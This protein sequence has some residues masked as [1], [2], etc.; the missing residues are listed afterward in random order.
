M[1]ALLLL[2]VAWQSH[3]NPEL[4]KKLDSMSKEDQRWRIEIMKIR[5][6]EKSAYTEDEINEQWKQA[7]SLNELKV[8]QIINQY[9]YPGYDMVGEKGS[10]D[11]WIIVQHCDD[12]VPFQEKV[13]R[14]MKKQIDLKNASKVN[15]A[16]LMDRVLVNKN[17]KQVYGTQCHLN[18]KTHKWG[19]FPLK[20]PSRVDIL[21]K[22]MG[23]EPLADYLKSMNK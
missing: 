20:D 22:S 5:N 17:Q 12:D 14:L 2:F 11:F 9:G 23:I 10:G 1:K 18:E 15:Y 7:D 3:Y 6:K 4:A 13:L 21:R 8:K 16:Y 19:P